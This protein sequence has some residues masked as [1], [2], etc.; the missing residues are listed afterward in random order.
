MTDWQIVFWH[1]L[2]LGIALSL[3]LAVHYRS[4]L[5]GVLR[6]MGWGGILG[7]VAFGPQ[8][9]PGDAGASQRAGR[10]CHVRADPSC[11]S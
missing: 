11:R 1:H 3:G 7:G 6:H 10:R 9:V 2:L 4:R 8:Y 5:G